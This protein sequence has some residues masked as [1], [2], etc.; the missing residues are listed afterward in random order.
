MY[1]KMV[2]SPETRRE[3][4]GL[5]M[6]NH[7]VRSCSDAPRFITTSA[8]SFYAADLVIGICPNVSV[9]DDVLC[10]HRIVL[11]VGNSGEP[12]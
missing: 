3:A 5:G 1:Q 12:D 10:V 8:N 4:R 9:S 11:S 7:T 2:Q 6:S